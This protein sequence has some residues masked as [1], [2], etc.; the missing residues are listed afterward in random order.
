MV[1]YHIAHADET[2]TVGEHLITPCAVEVAECMLDEQA[3]KK[4]ETIQ[5]SN[6]TVH[7]RI[8]NLS[9][10]IEDWMLLRLQLCVALYLQTNESKDVAR[11]ALLLVFLRY[12]YQ[13]KI[14]DVFFAKDLESRRAC[15]AVFSVIRTY[16]LE[17]YHPGRS[18]LMFVHME[19]EEWWEKWQVW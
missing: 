8:Q 15:D 13:N 11:L 14:E 19:P 18:M 7:R 10:S 9:D 6:N 16:M 17:Q 12:C 3:K 1:M 5:W 2:H 4:L